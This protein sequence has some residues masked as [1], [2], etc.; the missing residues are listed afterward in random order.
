MAEEEVVQALMD[1]SHETAFELEH[2]AITTEAKIT[3]LSFSDLVAG[4]H[5]CTGRIEV[6]RD[7]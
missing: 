6:S 1:A 2:H 3:T 7:G 5:L 4:R